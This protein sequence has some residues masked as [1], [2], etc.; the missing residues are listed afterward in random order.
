M[1]RFR[2]S[3]AE[4]EHDFEL[5]LASIIDCFTVLITYLLLSASFVSLGIFD[6]SVPVASLSSFPSQ[7]KKVTLTLIL[8]AHGGLSLK[9]EGGKEKPHSFFPSQA[10][11]PDYQS[12]LALLKKIHDEYPEVKEI[13]LESEEM[14][15]YA[16]IIHALE[17]IRPLFPQIAISGQKFES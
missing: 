8:Q 14:V 6:V 13:L 10:G 15:L 12:L 5:N 3:E 7:D 9:V 1:S 11:Q 16:D 17:K 4:A 2:K